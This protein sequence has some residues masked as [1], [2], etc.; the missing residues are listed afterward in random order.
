MKLYTPKHPVPQVIN[1][2]DVYDD[3]QTLYVRNCASVFDFKATVEGQGVVEGI[4]RYHPFLYDKETFPSDMY[5]PRSM[6]LFICI[7]MHFRPVKI[8][9]RFLDPLLSLLR[10]PHYQFVSRFPS[11]GMKSGLRTEVLTLIGLT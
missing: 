11:G 5:D 9:S 7:Y 8:I 10:V 6:Y 3:M 2:R 4:I 1:L